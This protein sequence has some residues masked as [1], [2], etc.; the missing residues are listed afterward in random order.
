MLTKRIIPCLDIKNGRTVKG[1]NFVDLRDAGDPVELAAKYAETGADELVFLDISATEE[2]RKT[3]ANL[4]LRV[5]EKINIPFTVGGGISSVEDVD[6]LLQN[7][8]DKVSINSSAV[9][10]PQLINDLAAKFGSQCVVVAIDAKQ[11]NG[12]WTVHLVGGKVPTE[13]DLFEWAKEVETRGAG[14]ILFTSMDHDGT[15]NG[16]ADEALAKLS[17]MLN[18]P[19][20]ASGGAGAMQHFTDTFVNGK[21]DAALAAS[22]FHFH[23]IDIPELKQVLKENNIPVRI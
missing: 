16:F 14:E 5:A 2:R 18:I 13:L 6:V 7:G 4:V 8:A 1:V 11:I 10:S 23:E 17:T 22:V 12:K 21:A 3:L 19:I 9:K 15:K 20:I